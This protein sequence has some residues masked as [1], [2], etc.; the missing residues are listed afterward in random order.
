[1]WRDTRAKRVGQKRRWAKSEAIL[2]MEKLVLVLNVYRQGKEKPRQ[3]R[4]GKG[5]KRGKLGF[6]KQMTRTVRRT[7]RQQGMR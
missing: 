1:M 4:V 6:S 5:S 3:E 2:S 7:G